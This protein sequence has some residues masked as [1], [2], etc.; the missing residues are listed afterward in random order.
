M[1]KLFLM[2]AVAMSQPAKPLQPTPDPIGHTAIADTDTMS[3]PILCALL[4]QDWINLL[5]QLIIAKDALQR[6]LDKGS[7]ADP[8]KV[9]ELN[10]AVAVLQQA[11]DD[12][13]LWYYGAGCLIPLPI[14]PF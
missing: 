4:M 2:L 3:N 13:A 6:E 1:T 7:E 11:A 10:A 8:A 12:A 5:D 9:F 14:G